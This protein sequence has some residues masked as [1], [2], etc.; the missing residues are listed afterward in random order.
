MTEKRKTVLDYKTI[1]VTGVKIETLPKH[2]PTEWQVDKPL[3]SSS[4][5]CNDCGLSTPDEVKEA[6]AEDPELKRYDGPKEEDG[7]FKSFLRNRVARYGEFGCDRCEVIA[8]EIAEQFVTGE[9]IVV[10][11]GM[12]Y[13]VAEEKEGET[14]YHV[15]RDIGEEVHTELN[16]PEVIKYFAGLE[17]LV[18]QEVDPKELL[19]PWKDFIGLGTYGIP[20]SKK[21]LGVIDL[22]E[23]SGDERTLSIQ[24]GDATIMN[25][26][27]NLKVFQGLAKVATITYEAK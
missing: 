13:T 24:L 17:K 11:D 14:K 5:Y 4:D 25:P 2:I 12:I 18:G 10:R 22:K 3:I 21:D 19:P 8:P 16:R 1:K 6:F 23:E 20:G 26:R 27:V 9:E 15:A 7:R